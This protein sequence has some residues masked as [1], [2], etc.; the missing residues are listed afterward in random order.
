MLVVEYIFE[1]GNELLL[2]INL[3]IGIFFMSEGNL[4]E[5]KVV[6]VERMMVS[7]IECKL[8]CDVVK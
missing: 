5:F 2:K 1:V 7:V 6:Y 4:F 8:V 3:V